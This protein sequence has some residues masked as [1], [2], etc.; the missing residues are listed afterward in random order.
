[1]TVADTPS[2]C[3]VTVR[4]STGAQAAFVPFIQSDTPPKVDNRTV[5]VG[6]YTVDVATTL[7]KVHGI[8]QCA[9]TLANL[10]KA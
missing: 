5:A 10:R 2:F 4:L 6:A 8:S 7:R 9:A 1:V 3:T